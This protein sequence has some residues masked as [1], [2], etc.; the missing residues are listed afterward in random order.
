VG[1]RKCTIKHMN[2][3]T[4]CTTNAKGCKY[5]FTTPGARKVSLQKPH[6]NSV[7]TMIIGI[8]KRNLRAG[9]GGT[10]L[11][12]FSTWGVEA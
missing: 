7:T 5:Y 10:C 9:C 3:R 1:D 11:F 4:L 2:C 12:N 8:Q 6:T